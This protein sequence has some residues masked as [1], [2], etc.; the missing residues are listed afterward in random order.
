MMVELSIC[1]KVV[2]A[3]KQLEKAERIEGDTET[4]GVATKKVTR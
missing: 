2:A 1:Q 4:E 3:L